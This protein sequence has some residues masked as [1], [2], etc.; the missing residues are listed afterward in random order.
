[1]SWLLI[2]LAALLL[3]L[4]DDLLRL[5]KNFAALPRIETDK[6]MFGDPPPQLSEA[7]RTY[8]ESRFLVRSGASTW[9]LG[10]VFILAGAVCFVVGIG[11]LEL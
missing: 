6:L 2:A 7:A 5:T 3:W 4:G 11:W 10:Y 9:L 8:A 1:M